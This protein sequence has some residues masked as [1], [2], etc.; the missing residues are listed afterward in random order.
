MLKPKLEIRQ[1][2]GEGKYSWA[3]FRAD[4]TKPMCAGI[5]KYHAEHLQIILGRM[6]D[7]P[8]SFPPIKDWNEYEEIVDVDEDG[9]GKRNM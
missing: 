9:Y 2:H 7:L 5:S 1:Y 4:R 8:E 3:I 6:K